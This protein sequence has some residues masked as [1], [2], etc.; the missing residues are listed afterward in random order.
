MTLTAESA[1]PSAQ[2]EAIEDAVEV[3]ESGGTISSGLA[4]SLSAN[5][6]AARDRV[7]DQPRA[8]AGMLTAFIQRV[9]A[10]VRAGRLNSA[11]GNNLISA[12]QNVIAGLDGLNN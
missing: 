1:D 8:A 3:L 4:A 5:L 10:L 7:D 12:A 6:G 9:T 2:I 11:D